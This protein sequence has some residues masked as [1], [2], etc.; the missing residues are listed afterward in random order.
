MDVNALPNFQN[1]VIKQASNNSLQSM[2]SIQSMQSMQT[3]NINSPRSVDSRNSINTPNSKFKP[4]N[5]TNENNK[6]YNSDENSNTNQN[7]N[8][9]SKFKLVKRASEIIKENKKQGLHKASFEVKMDLNDTEFMNVRLYRLIYIDY[10][11]LNILYVNLYIKLFLLDFNF[12][13]E[14]ANKKLPRKSLC[15]RVF[16]F[17]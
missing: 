12:N 10:F 1:N 2:Q 5:N 4:S 11:I 8:K 3:D 16:K 13:N 14:K 15:C 7:E 17:L 6:D 9:T